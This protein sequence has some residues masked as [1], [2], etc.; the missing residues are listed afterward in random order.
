MAS[1][2]AAP[3][4]A[5]TT[6]A[7]NSSGSS[8]VMSEAEG[9]D[10]EDKS[11]DIERPSSVLWERVIRQTILIDLSDNESLHFN[12]LQGTFNICLSQD[13]AP[14]ASFHLSENMDESDSREDTQD[15]VTFS[16]SS[17]L[18][19]SCCSQAGGAQEGLVQGG[20][21]QSSEMRVS[22]QRP[23]TMEASLAYE[24]EE[25]GDTS[26]EE[27]EDLPYDGDLSLDLGNTTGEQDLGTMDQS[28]REAKLED[29][30]PAQSP[31]VD[32][33]SINQAIVDNTSPSLVLEE[34]GKMYGPSARGIHTTDCRM[35]V[36]EGGEGLPEVHGYTRPT[37]A[38]GRSQPNDAAAHSNIKEL[39]LQH[40]SRDELLNS[41]LYIEAETMPE[42]SFADSVDET[43]LSKALL[44]LKLGRDTSITPGDNS[45]Q[46]QE[47]KMTASEEEGK[48]KAKE[49]QENEDTPS[50][51]SDI[52]VSPVE[53]PMEHGRPGS[54][55]PDN[56]G[57]QIQN[58][59]LGRARSYN[60][61]KYGQGQVH[62][63]LP[64]FSKVAPKVKIPKAGAAKPVCHQPGILRAQSSPGML[65]KSPASCKATV[66]LIN[67]VL[68][69]S[70]QPSETPYVFSDQPKHHE[71]APKS[72]ELVQ[73]L[74]A[75]YDKLLTKYAEAENLIDQMRLGTKQAQ[76]PVDTVAFEGLDLL[77]VQVPETSVHQLDQPAKHRHPTYRG[78]PENLDDPHLDTC[79][80]QTDQSQ[81][82]EGEKMTTELMEII[83]QYMEKV[84]DFQNCLNLMSIG[85]SE[86]Q[87][88]FKSLMDAQDQLERNYIAKKEEH[89]ALEM[90]NYMGLATNTG[91]FDPERTVEGEIF[92]IGM[93]LED[94]R[95]L[96]DRNVRSQLSLP[97]SSSAPAP[98]LPPDAIFSPPPSA[99][100]EPSSSSENVGTE[101]ATAGLPHAPAHVPQ[102]HDDPANKPECSGHTSTSL[103]HLD[104]SLERLG[105][106]IRAE[107]EEEEADPSAGKARNGAHL[108]LQSMTPP[109][110]QETS[111]RSG[112]V[113]PWGC[114]GNA[115]H[116]SVTQ[117]Q[118]LLP[119]TQSVSQVQR[120]V[121]PETDSGFG[122]S[123]LSP[124][125]AEQ[126]PSQSETERSRLYSEQYSSPVNTSGSDSEASSSA[127]QTTT[128]HNALSWKPGEGLQQMNGVDHG[129]YGSEGVNTGLTGGGSHTSRHPGQ[130]GTDGH[131]VPPPQTLSLSNDWPLGRMAPAEA[132]GHI[133]SCHNEAISALQSEVA[134]L[135]QE[136]E[137]SLFQ[138]PHITKRMD[139]LASRYKQE[140]RPKSRSRANIRASP[141]SDLRHSGY[142]HR[143]ETLMN[144]DSDLLKVEDWI[145]S[146]ME[147]SKTRMWLTSFSNL[148]SF[149]LQF[150]LWFSV[151][152]SVKH[153]QN[154][155]KT[156]RS[157]VKTVCA[158]RW[159]LRA[160]VGVFPKTQQYIPYGGDS[161]Q[162]VRP[163]HSRN[164][165]QVGRGGD[166]RPHPRSDR[167]GRPRSARRESAVI[168]ATGNVETIHSDGSPHPNL[169]KPPQK[170][171][172]QVN[173]G[174]SYSLPAGFKALEPQPAGQQRGRS[175]QSDSALLPSNIYFQRPRGRAPASSR[176]S[177]PCT[178]RGSEDE[179]ISRTLD[180][181]I[182]AARSMKR[183]TDRMAQ[184]LSADL[185]KAELQRKLSG[186]CPRRRRENSDS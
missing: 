81:P 32:S 165:H 153:E 89:R 72:T 39:L 113:L 7:G 86:Q 95:E 136:L 42:V 181:A 99:C 83:N 27:Q 182:E 140:K 92:R 28:E 52:A 103:H 114:G 158:S 128:V 111:E 67:K 132:H 13:S 45:G 166:G 138:L 78:H 171:L 62:Y 40:F 48:Q 159:S 167:R 104:P 44:S 30:L 135:K 15:K 183:R 105:F 91:E 46:S 82:S 110:P 133:C 117:T 29:E 51:G 18:D 20:G 69:D 109:S 58:S 161:C 102:T 70:I 65:G 21:A 57:V 151:I 35:W 144:T 185:A 176:S 85:V 156:L 173:Y 170:S 2:R 126:P 172:L 24:Y 33:G 125:A 26:E 87:M 37:E 175:T 100:E 98:S 79:P 10:S 75:E 63:P 88:V 41:S 59:F 96:I 3:R 1:Q 68:E 90:Q 5:E 164:S 157:G 115:A 120:T 74:Q 146:D 116:S 77:E 76:G 127:M 180:R 108:P 112:P 163:E 9:E 169:M 143:K 139:Y 101:K 137:E 14:E 118:T 178:Y 56:D 84:D 147:P 121:T 155:T 16:E 4:M 23:N 22:V 71:D 8:E 73:H 150:L 55:D 154:K 19:N 38:V 94:I 25:A 61:L 179:D 174:S 36:A 93:R 186:L 152:N 130:C 162:S 6:A 124:P 97:A 122:S 160:F 184:S 11:V 149:R 177:S 54:P 43:T 123:D 60:E 119:Q 141:S 53:E 34:A 134:R 129:A 107:E 148:K 106:G 31:T 64:D 142:R 47:G 66:D 145:S 131:L 17:L 80:A 50:T 49:S 12:D 168:L